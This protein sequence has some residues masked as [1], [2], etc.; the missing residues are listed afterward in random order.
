MKIAHPTTDV[1][2]RE[3]YYEFTSIDYTEKGILPLN[4]PL[5][6]EYLPDKSIA[7]TTNLVAM[8]GVDVFKEI[9]VTVTVGD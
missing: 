3:L 6:G 9:D 5:T 7:V 8:T 1:P 2:L 4:E